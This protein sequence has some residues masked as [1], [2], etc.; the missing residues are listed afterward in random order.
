MKIEYWIF[1][2]EYW[3]ADRTI[4]ILQHKFGSCGEENKHYYLIQFS[5]IAFTDHSIAKI[6]ILFVDC[7]EKFEIGIALIAVACLLYEIIFR[8]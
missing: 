4:N 8:F 1:D 2:I 6:N 3:A 7:W 5:I